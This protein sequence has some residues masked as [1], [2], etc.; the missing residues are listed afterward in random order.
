MG[1][2]MKRM[3]FGVTHMTQDP[4][5]IIED[6][7]QAA[8]ISTAEPITVQTEDEKFAKTTGVDAEVIERHANR[9]L[10]LFVQANRWDPN[11]GNETFDDID[12]AM[13][14][15]DGKNE[16]A[17][18]GEVIDNSPYVEVSLASTISWAE[19]FASY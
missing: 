4:T 15:G 2:L 16:T 6:E 8:E 3:G 14:G 10:S 12:A 11:I 18:V 13:D 19:V 9:R 7:N 17:M 1:S 5:R